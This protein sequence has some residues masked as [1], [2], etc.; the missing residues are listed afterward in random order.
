VCMRT[1]ACSKTTE[2]R[3]SMTPSVSSRPRFA[4]TI[5]PPFGAGQGAAE[6]DYQRRRDRSRQRRGAS[7]Y[8]GFQ[9]GSLAFLNSSRWL[10][11]VGLMIQMPP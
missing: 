8:S 1:P 10:A 11:P 4:T 5:C 7:R 3:P 9:A 2:C 6:A